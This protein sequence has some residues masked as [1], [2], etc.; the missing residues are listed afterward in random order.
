MLDLERT[1]TVQQVEKRNVPPPRRPS[2]AQIGFTLIPIALIV[3][4]L[5]LSFQMGSIQLWNTSTNGMVFITAVPDVTIT[6]MDEGTGEVKV[7]LSPRLNSEV[8]IFKPIP[9]LNAQV[10]GNPKAPEISLS[11]NATKPEAIPGLTVRIAPQPLT[12][13]SV[14]PVLD[15]LPQQALDAINPQC[16]LNMGVSVDLKKMTAIFPGATAKILNPTHYGMPANSTMFQFA[17]GSVGGC[18]PDGLAFSPEGLVD[19]ETGKV[20]AYPQGEVWLE[21]RHLPIA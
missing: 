18:I 19:Q 5:T 2:N 16:L 1:R 7:E 4:S 17:D 6:V 10:V 12:P 20:W 3:I 15:S 9:S 14:V 21:D 13:S 8:Q 11:A